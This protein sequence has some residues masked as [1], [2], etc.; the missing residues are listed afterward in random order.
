MSIHIFD[1]FMKLTIIKEIFFQLLIAI[2]VIAQQKTKA[3]FFSA[4]MANLFTNSANIYNAN[5]KC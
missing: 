3:L 2:C 5:A 1:D 4:H